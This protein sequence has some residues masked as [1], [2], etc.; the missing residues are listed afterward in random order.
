VN[1]YK[2]ENAAA[3]QKYAND[4]RST[5]QFN[6]ITVLVGSESIPANKLVLSSY[7]K[8]FKFMLLSPM[9]ERNQNEVEIQQFDGKAVRSLV[10][11]M[12]C[13]EININEGMY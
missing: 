8:F 11:F 10:D 4:K 9:K 7:S 2:K 13:G 6:D 3:L 12:Y 1:K 5:D